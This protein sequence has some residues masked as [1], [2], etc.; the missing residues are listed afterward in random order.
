MSVGILLLAAGSS[1]RLGQSKQLLPVDSEPLLV[2]AVRTALASGANKTVVVLGAHAPAHHTVIT[3]YPVEVT[4]NDDWQKGMGHSLKKGLLH[5]ITTAPETQAVLVMVCDQPMLEA[6]H[7]QRLI[8]ELGRSGRSI[9]ASYYNGS[10]GVPAIFTYHHFEELLNLDDQHGAK[11]VILRHQPTIGVID[12][13]GGAVDL[14]TPEDY[15]SFL[16][17]R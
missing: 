6:S 12:F 16:N 15:R 14:D 3:H 8:L 4:V 5:L 9:V 7:L 13:P 10:P 11:K 17:N 1:S 2:R